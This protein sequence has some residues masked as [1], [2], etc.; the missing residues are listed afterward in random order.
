M[1][2]PSSPHPPSGSRSPFATDDLAY[3]TRRMNVRTPSSGSHGSPEP[4]KGHASRLFAKRRDNKQNTSSASQSSPFEVVLQDCT[5]LSEWNTDSYKPH[6]S[7]A[8][9]TNPSE[10]STITAL[11]LSDAGFLAVAWSSKLTIVDLRG[12]EVLYSEEDQTR[13]G[14]ITLLTW[15]VCSEGEGEASYFNNISIWTCAHRIGPLQILKDSHGCSYN[16]SQAPY[17]FSP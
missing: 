17:G 11:K 12:P 14:R 7:L 16:T 13:S 15:A 2:H 9:V 4:N 3:M 6:F 1:S 8:P 5:H 10:S